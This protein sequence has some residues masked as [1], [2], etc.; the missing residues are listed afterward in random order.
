MLYTDS[1]K[2]TDVEHEVNGL[3]TYGRISRERFK[4]WWRLI[5]SNLSLKNACIL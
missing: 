3:V 2:T 4:K 5:Y 1:K